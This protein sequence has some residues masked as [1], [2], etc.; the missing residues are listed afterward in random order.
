[1]RNAYK[2]LVSK[3]EG[4]RSVGRLWECNII[5]FSFHLHLIIFWNKS[6]IDGWQTNLHNGEFRKF[7]RSPGIVTWW[8]REGWDER[9][10]NTEARRGAC[11][12]GLVEL[13]MDSKT[14]T[15]VL[16]APPHNSY[17]IALFFIISF[18]L[19]TM[20][21]KMCRGIICELS[22]TSSGWSLLAN[23]VFLRAF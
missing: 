22:W 21:I 6:L 23:I 7:C 16:A 19:D 17:S 20:D 18:S 2:I 11:R 1:M 5:G 9:N 15:N 13:G 12:G 10:C 8:N 3:L 4:K 14:I